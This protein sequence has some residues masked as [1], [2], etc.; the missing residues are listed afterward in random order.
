MWFVW[1]GETLL[2]YSE[3]NTHKLRHVERSPKVSVNFNTDF[4]GEHVGVLTGEARVDPDAP[5]PDENSDYLAKYGRGIAALGMT[6][7]E[8]ARDYNV[9]LRITPRKMRGF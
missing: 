6:P 3:P 5:P 9:A 7:A 1:D 8:V 4:D 2:V